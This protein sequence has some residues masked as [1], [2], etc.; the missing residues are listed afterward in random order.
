[1]ENNTIREVYSD[2]NYKFVKISK[3]GSDINRLI[4]E[5]DSIC[6][7]PFDTNNG[8][9]KNIY[10]SKYN[11]YVKNEDSYTCINNGSRENYST[12]YEDLED[13]IKS[14]LGIDVT[15][16]DLYYL[17]PIQHSIPFSKSY[18]CYGLNLDN[19]C[20][21]LNGFTPKISKSELES[22]RYSLSK[23]KFNRVLN[24]DI[25]DSLCLASSMLLLSYLD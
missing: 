6:I 4:C 17:G 22:K 8:K 23:I 3:D 15:V 14:E 5:K 19:Y 12:H 24:G 20:D 11:D 9:I 7:L 10:L 1:M 25:S 16:D 13:F 18:K 21:D 2:G